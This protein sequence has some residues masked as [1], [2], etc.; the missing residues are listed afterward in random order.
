MGAIEIAVQGAKRL[1]SLLQ[2]RFGAEGRGLHE[3]LTS[4]EN[5]IPSDVRK[6]IRWVAT[7]RNNVVHEDGP[8][9][10]MADFVR[11]VERIAQKLE[12]ASRPRASQPKKRAAGRRVGRRRASR[13]RSHLL[14]AVALMAAAALALVVAFSR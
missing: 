8:H 1:E 4:V 7:I 9:P 3:K 14:L 13:P 5:K 12:V 6:S 2:A 11:T 10:S